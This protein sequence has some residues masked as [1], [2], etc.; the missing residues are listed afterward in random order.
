MAQS[1]FI[2]RGGY[3]ATEITKGLLRTQK[4]LV[5]F[6][7][8]SNQALQKA[9]Q[10]L[11]QTQAKQASKVEKQYVKSVNAV[12]GAIG[13]IK[14]AMAA[15]AV[16]TFI[17]DTTSMA[18]NVESSI[19]Q[20]SRTMGNNSTEFQKWVKAQ[21]SAFGMS[22]SEAYQYGAVYSNLISGFAKDT[23][24]TSKY[25]QQLLEASAVVASSTG[26]TMEDTMERIRSGLLGNTEAIEDLGIN[27]NVAMIQSTKAF[28]QFANGKSWQQLDF[29]T[30]QQIRL[31]AIL[32]QANL[33]YG[34]SLAGT[35]ATK[36]MAFVATLKNIQLNLGQAFLP[37]YNTILPALTAFASKI[38]AITANF[39]AF[40][41]ALFGKSTTY[42]VNNTASAIDG[43]AS[44]ITD[45]G[46]A[47]QKAGEKAKKSTASF[48][49]LKVIGGSSSSSSGGSTSSGSS[50]GSTITPTENT[51]TNSVSASLKELQKLLSPTTKALKNLYDNGLKKLGSFTA[52]GLK[53][54]Y[55][56]FLVPVGKWTLGTGLPGL[57]NSTNNLLNNVDWKKLNQSLANLWDK[58]TPFTKNVGEGLLWFYDN[59]LMKVA[60]VAID[61]TLPEF[62]DTLSSAIDSLNKAT[63]KFKKSDLGKGIG[64][65]ISNLPVSMLKDITKWIEKMGDAFENLGDFIDKPT[66]SNFKD[67]VLDVYEAFFNS[68]FS[69]TESILAKGVKYLTGFDLNEW[70]EEKI[71][72]W[73]HADKW[74]QTF[75]GIKSSVTTWKDKMFTWFGDVKTT[76]QTKGKHVLDG[77]Q[78]GYDIAK[79]N[80]TT[81]IQGKPAEILGWFGDIKTKFQTKGK[82]ILDGIED[83]WENA[84]KDFTAWIQTKPSDIVTWF[85]DIKTKFQGKGKNIIDGIKIGWNNGWKDFKK[86]LSD[87]PSQIANGIGSLQSIGKDMIND[88]IKGFKSISLPKI[89]IG[90]SYDTEGLAGKLGKALNLPGF[91]RLNLD[92]YANGGFPTPGQLFVANEPGNPELIGNIGG[93]TAVANGDQIT[94][95]IATAVAS[96]IEP[97]MALIRETN[98]LLRQIYNKPNLSGND[99]LNAVTKEASK[100]QKISGY[101]PLLQF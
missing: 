57:I 79:K 48:D 45:L 71:E 62:L 19:N 6:Q 16:G 76:F 23:A 92:F 78:E 91:P 35:T 12:S 52:T 32:E 89:K 87:L 61:E 68:P 83:G 18:M 59:V 4:E 17:K 75:E 96:V 66:L 63:D 98:A 94:T 21:A 80:F 101:N 82:H 97:S 15:V 22:K 93:K 40:S 24:E 73:F 25:T 58:L 70:Y 65:F 42:Q 95:G 37:I 49:E 64:D 3:D 44:A 9:Q 38:E 34:D 55:D 33:K 31:M 46:T 51:G 41:Q 53:D 86:W 47:A 85:G 74:N 54:F 1:N 5:K 8:K 88:F 39:A 2:V 77:I 50:G 100:S 14:K 11:S 28:K 29:Q 84:K 26:R 99:I 69:P 56:K 90:V 72:P 7:N 60:K 81:W 36:Q 43:Q 20:I 67:L 27:V 30:Q 10:K 13:F